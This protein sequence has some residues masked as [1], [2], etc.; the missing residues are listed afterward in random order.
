MKEDLN[1]L[2]TVQLLR[3]AQQQKLEKEQAPNQSAPMKMHAAYQNFLRHLV[4]VGLCDTSEIVM[5]S[6]I[7]QRN[8]GDLSDEM[9]PS[10]PQAADSEKRSRMSMD[11]LIAG[12]GDVQEQ[13]QQQ[14]QQQ[15]NLSDANL[16]QQKQKMEEH[17]RKLGGDLDLL[18]NNN[19]KSPVSAMGS[20]GRSLS[21]Q[22]TKS[23]TA[24]GKVGSGGNSKSARDGGRGERSSPPAST[25][26]V[27]RGNASPIDDLSEKER[28]ERKRKTTDGGGSE[29][30]AS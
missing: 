6:G 17:L 27:T 13:Q 21:P 11:S 1:D 9:Q 5:L 19:G 20:T 7:Q 18:Q 30:E 22:S 14:K 29:R 24:G 4:H 25:A 15:Q 8:N 10:S 26:S 2:S 28:L 12:G 16:E 23:S 3:L